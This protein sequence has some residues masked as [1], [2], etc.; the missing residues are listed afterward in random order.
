MAEISGK[1]LC[2]AVSFMAEVGQKAVGACHCSKCRQWSG[3]PFLGIGCDGGKISVQGEDNL[4]VYESSPWGERCFCK[5]C[6]SVLFWRTRDKRH[7]EASAGCLDETD[8][9]TFRREIFIDEKPVF[10]SFAN[11]TEKLTGAEFVALIMGDSAK[12]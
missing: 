1:C 5:T 2:G 8:G 4:S 3:G 6:G 9:L 11:D 12:S 7:W 10:Y